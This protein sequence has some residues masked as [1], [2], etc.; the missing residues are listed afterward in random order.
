MEEKQNEEKL[1]KK[2]KSNNSN[3]KNTEL[4]TTTPLQTPDIYE[5]QIAVGWASVLRKQYF[6][7]RC[8]HYWPV[9]DG[10][11]DGQLRSAVHMFSKWES[12]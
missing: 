1:E 8:L 9:L 3:N 6:P 12:G 5:R 2:K 7:I 11:L 4:N 10:E